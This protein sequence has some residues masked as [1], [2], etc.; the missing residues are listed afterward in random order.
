MTGLTEQ[1]ATSYHY[2]TT[3]YYPTQPN[4]PHIKPPARSGGAEPGALIMA[5]ANVMLMLIQC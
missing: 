2:T 1:Y 5:N 4:P 3:N